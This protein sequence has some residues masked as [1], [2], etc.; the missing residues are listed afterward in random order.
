MAD[1]NKPGPSGLHNDNA[2]PAEEQI[3]RI[4]NRF[5]QRERQRAQVQQ[6]QA[7]QAQQAQSPTPKSN[8]TTPLRTGMPASP[9]NR[10]LDRVKA[11]DDPF[12]DKDKGRALPPPAE[13]PAPDSPEK[14]LRE[15]AIRWYLNRQATKGA[16]GSGSP[17][18]QGQTENTVSE[19]VAESNKSLIPPGSD[20]ACQAGP[21]YEVSNVAEL[22]QFLA[23]ADRVI[24]LCGSPVVE[25]KYTVVVV[26]A[27]D[28]GLLV[29]GYGDAEEEESAGAVLEMLLAGHGLWEANEQSNR[30]VGEEGH[31]ENSS[32]SI[33]STTYRGSRSGLTQWEETKTGAKGQAGESSQPKS[34]DPAGSR[35]GQGRP[36]DATLTFTIRS[37]DKGKG[38]EEAAAPVTRRL[39]SPDARKLVEA[40]LVCDQEEE[41]EE[42]SKAERWKSPRSKSR[43]LSDSTNFQDHQQID[44]AFRNYQRN[45]FL[46]VAEIMQVLARGEK[47]ENPG[48][49]A[50][51]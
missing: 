37:P 15:R 34:P 8:Q 14:S 11:D 46:Q 7:Q 3:R 24:S 12:V 5:A 4:V 33:A 49:N 42:R 29:R 27:A 45:V 41:E 13:Q 50:K 47:E 39:L 38:K 16:F 48:I 19:W 22:G 32:H 28:L 18:K 44:T 21:H 31:T 6:A 26:P 23:S 17:Q 2:Q 40:V 10:L 51:I 36:L 43:R 25:M 35:P 20:L 1:P 9:T 30:Q